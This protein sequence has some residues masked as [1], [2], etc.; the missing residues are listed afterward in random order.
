MEYEG[1][2]KYLNLLWQK[3]EA[4]VWILAI[5][6]LALQ[7]PGAHHYSICPLDRLGFDF[8]PGCGLG[9]SVT[10]LFHLDIEASFS[11]HPLGIPAVI[12]LLTRSVRVLLNR[13]YNVQYT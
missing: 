8:C 5:V 4:F 6:I 1:L 9:R 2:K 7:E 11:T 10:Y 13:S 3:R 12:L